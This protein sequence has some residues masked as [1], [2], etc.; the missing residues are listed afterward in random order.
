MAENHSWNKVQNLSTSLRVFFKLLV[1]GLVSTRPLCKEGV[2]IILLRSREKVEWVRPLCQLWNCSLGECQ[3]LLMMP[4]SSMVIFT[5]M[6]SLLW[7]LLF[8]RNGMNEVFYIWILPNF[9][10]SALK[11]RFSPEPSHIMN[12]VLDNLNSKNWE[13]R[14]EGGRWAVRQVV[15]LNEDSGNLLQCLFTKWCS[16]Q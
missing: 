13:K 3:R 14:K 15:F 5:V 16:I 4:Y 12:S 1:K 11:C 6:F 10:Y 8:W 7:V 2:G 9:W